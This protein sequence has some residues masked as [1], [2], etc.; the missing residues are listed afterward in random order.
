MRTDSR[1][2]WRTFRL[3]VVGLCLACGHAAVAKG[4]TDARGGGASGVTSYRGTAAPAG[5]GTS[6]PG[7]GGGWS[8]VGTST[9]ASFTNARGGGSGSGG[10]ATFTGVASARGSGPARSIRTVS[11]RMHTSTS[12][13][14]RK[15]TVLASAPPAGRKPAVTVSV[16]RE[17]AAEQ[18]RRVDVSVHLQASL[19]ADAARARPSTTVSAATGSAAASPSRDPRVAAALKTVAAAPTIGRNPFGSRGAAFATLPPR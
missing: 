14:P 15:S 13:S 8:G 3:A 2:T 1:L 10:V 19:K 16:D 18:A 11:P 7:R 12:A 4:G 17:R 5:R 6:K 9:V